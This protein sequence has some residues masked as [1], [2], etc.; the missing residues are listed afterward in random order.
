MFF[1]IDLVH[2][3]WAFAHRGKRDLFS[4]YVF[5]VNVQPHWSRNLGNSMW[6]TPVV[7]SIRWP[8]PLKQ[9]LC[10]TYDE[11]ILWPTDASES[12]ARVIMKSLLL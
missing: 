3:E 7:P 9:G 6:N 8:V 11:S 4:K 12:S 10:L 2:R 1:D 5:R